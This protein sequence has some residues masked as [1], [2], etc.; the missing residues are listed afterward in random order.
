MPNPFVA[1]DKP[2]ITED[3]DAPA[4]HRREGDAYHAEVR[5]VDQAKQGQSWLGW[6]WD[7][8]DLSREE[9]RL[10]FK[11]DAS[12][13]IFASVRFD[14]IFAAASA[15]NAFFFLWACSSATL[16]R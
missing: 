11:V 14:R 8:A 9:R 12:L 3:L 15:P 6:V 2:F 1:N 4:L 16:S 7:T 5:V 13:L 10:L